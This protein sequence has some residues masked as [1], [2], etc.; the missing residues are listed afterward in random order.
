[1][2]K[3][4][5]HGAPHKNRYV[6]RLVIEF[7]SERAVLHFTVSLNLGGADLCYYSEDSYLE[8]PKL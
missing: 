5:Q 1:V 3:V 2:L 4:Q 6:A 7:Y 8:H